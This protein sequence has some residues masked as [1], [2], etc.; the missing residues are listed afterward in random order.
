MD[1]ELDSFLVTVYVIVD[2]L[3]LAEC[4]PRKP[5]RPGA[6]PQLSDSE[7]VTL[8]ILAQWQRRRSERAF[9]R[10]GKASLQPYF[11]RWLS[12]S[13]FN[14]RLRDLAGVLAHLAPRIAERT[15]ELLG[16]SAYQ[17][18]DGVPV[19]LM[20]RCRGQRQRCFLTEAAIGRGGSDKDWFYGQRLLLSVDVHGSISGAVSGPANTE[21]HW[22]A[23]ALFGRRVDSLGPDPTAWELDPLLGPAHRGGG[24]RQGPTGPLGLR[25]AAGVPWP[26]PYLGDQGYRGTDWRAHWQ[27]AYQATVLLK[28][29]YLAGPHRQRFCGLRQVVE[30]VNGYLEEHLGLWFPRAKTAWGLETRLGAK[31]LASNLARYFN[32]LHGRSPFSALEF[33]WSA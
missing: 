24:Q 28:M 6:R 10:L 19:P 2:E 15:A 3:Y 20:R 16:P 5:I 8:G 7:V 32:A 11:P 21:E 17:V 29:D 4:L 22:L 33:A 30:S 12:Q 31:L 18:L 26:D 1:A 23:E 27:E 25:L 13:A 14:R 9:L